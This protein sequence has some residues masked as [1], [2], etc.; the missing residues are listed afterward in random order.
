MEEAKQRRDLLYLEGGDSL[1]DMLEKL[2][3][4][5][6]F[7]EMEE[8]LNDVRDMGD[9][10]EMVTENWQVVPHCHH[11]C[12]CHHHLVVLPPICFFLYKGHLLKVLW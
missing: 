5:E 9:F 4:Q 2:D 7:D 6:E 12:H 1:V 10:L 8:R 11:N 3:M